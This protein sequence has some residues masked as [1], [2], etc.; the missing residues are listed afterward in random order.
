MPKPLTEYAW[1]V[2]GHNLVLNVPELTRLY[3]DES[4]KA[5]RDAAIRRLVDLSASAREKVRLVF[6]GEKFPAGQPGGAEMG[7]LSVQFVDPPAEAD[8]WIVRLAR[9]EADK[10]SPVAVA[11][12]DRGL[13]ARLAGSP[14]IHRMMVD[15][16]WRESGRIVRKRDGDAPSEKQAPERTAA[17]DIEEMETAM[18]KPGAVDRPPA[19]APRA[20]APVKEARVAH[21]AASGSREGEASGSREGRAPGSRE[22]RAPGSREGRSSGSRDEGRG[23]KPAPPPAPVQAASAPPPP[24]PP[25]APP[26]PRVKD[27]R[28]LLADKKEKGRQRQLKRQG[29]RKEG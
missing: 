20:A 14:P 9:Q 5:A 7:G 16:F 24:P 1:I 25:P 18:S 6:D 3:N 13:L 11:T 10:G 28:E 4:K 29:R 23:A 12:S 26:P 19:P 22:G 2:D 15:A 27:W 17:R 21:D 8:D